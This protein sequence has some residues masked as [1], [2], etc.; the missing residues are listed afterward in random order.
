[1]RLRE[2]EIFNRIIEQ[3]HTFSDTQIFSLRDWL[4]KYQ[5]SVT[6]FSRLVKVDKAHISRLM[7]NKKRPSPQL[8]DHIKV[9]TNGKIRD[10]DDLI[11]PF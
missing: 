5:I 7:K 11:D 6:D 1:M 2:S 4:N 3:H 10:I 8:M 9:I